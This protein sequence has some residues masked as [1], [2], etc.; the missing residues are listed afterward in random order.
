MAFPGCV[1][2]PQVF[3]TLKHQLRELFPS[4]T[5]RPS[6]GWGRAAPSASVASAPSG[7]SSPSWA[8]GQERW[9]GCSRGDSRRPRGA[10]GRGLRES[11]LFGLRRPV[12]A[13]TALPGLPDAR[14]PALWAG[15]DGGC[16]T[17][18]PGGQSCPVTHGGPIHAGT[19]SC[20][21]CGTAMQQGA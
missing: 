5:F 10:A 12:S 21:R 17:C 2:Q 19:I 13:G 11:L 3:F 4:S 9:R 16:Q 18:S 14:W 7:P 1:N 15:L 20:P 6:P 8:L